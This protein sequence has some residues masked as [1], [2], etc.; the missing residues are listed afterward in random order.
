MRVVLSR[1]VG[2]GILEF[3]EM[4]KTYDINDANTTSYQY[5]NQKRRKIEETA[6]VEI[7]DN[8]IIIEAAVVKIMKRKK[9]MAKT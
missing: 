1:L 2:F 5:R 6:V 4:N 3:N 7:K 9:V 8:S